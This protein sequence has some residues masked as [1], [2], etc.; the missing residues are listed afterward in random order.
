GMTSGT[1]FFAICRWS[2]NVFASRVLRV[3][4]G[5]TSLPFT[6]HACTYLFRPSRLPTPFQSA[7]RFL[8]KACNCTGVVGCKFPGGGPGR[9]QPCPVEATSATGCDSGV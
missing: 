6:C 4:Q 3:A 7:E 5:D 1:E 8:P 2:A 9:L